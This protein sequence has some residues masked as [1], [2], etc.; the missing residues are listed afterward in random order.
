MLGKYCLLFTIIIIIFIII[1]I[2]IY[3]PLGIQNLNNWE[4]TKE[5]QVVSSKWRQRANLLF[6]LALVLIKTIVNLV[7]AWWYPL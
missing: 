4:K 2:V 6:L 5:I 1:I 7:L 3:I